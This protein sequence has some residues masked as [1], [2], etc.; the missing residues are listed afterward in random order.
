MWCL[1]RGDG[2]HCFNRATSARLTFTSSCQVA[3][4]GSSLASRSSIAKLASANRKALGRSDRPSW[5][6]ASTV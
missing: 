5:T 4:W 3:F 2:G 1:L 6:W